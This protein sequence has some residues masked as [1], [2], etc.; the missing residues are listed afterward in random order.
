M[1]VKVEVPQGEDATRA[2]MDEAC[3]WLA[4]RG[5]EA[6]RAGFCVGAL[7][8]PFVMDAYDVLA[9]SMRRQNPP[10]YHRMLKRA[11][12]VVEKGM[13][14]YKLRVTPELEKRWQASRSGFSSTRPTTPST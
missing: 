3:G 8:F 10:Y 11:G 1:S 2:L 6:A 9:P 13:V 12:F 14:D 5:T 7:E 4:E